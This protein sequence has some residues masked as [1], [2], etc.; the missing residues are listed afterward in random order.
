M[1]RVIAIANQKGGVGKT[2]TS[3]NLAASFAS[4]GLRTLLIDCD[5]QSN[6]TSGLGLPK[7]T[8]RYGT[9]A[10]LM[11]SDSDIDAELL[12]ELLQ[13]GLLQPTAIDLLKISPASKNLTDV[14]NE[15]ARENYREYRLLHNLRSLQ[16]QFDIIVLDCP[17][18]L[19]LLTINALVAADSVLVPMQA[20]YFALE[21]I[22]ELFSTIEHIRSTRNPRL[23]VEGVALTMYDDRTNL[24][25]GVT[26]EL[27][28]F[29]G[30]L[31]YA[32]YI[33]R[34]IR[35]AEAPSHGKPVILYDPQSRGAMAYLKLA[36]EVLERIKDRAP[37]AGSAEISPAAGSKDRADTPKSEVKQ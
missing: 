19:D 30:E 25:Q 20:E 16:D 23:I 6:S 34:N 13:K 14:S 4:S 31:L 5:P 35:L 37:A 26:A 33:P 32:T 11:L 9:Y 15:L 7:D 8:E 18:S 12:Q 28:S 27:K 21:G 17:P 22:T 36:Q 29:Y 10:L 2:T 3:I 1:S 24:A